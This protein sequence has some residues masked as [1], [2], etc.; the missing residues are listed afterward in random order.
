MK[1]LKHPPVK[2]GLYWVK[3]Q[4][5]DEAQI[6]NVIEPWN[7]IFKFQVIGQEQKYDMRCALAWCSRRPM[8]PQME[9]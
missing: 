8:K 2:K 9:K 5:F 1:W 4:G 3:V 6:V 7:G